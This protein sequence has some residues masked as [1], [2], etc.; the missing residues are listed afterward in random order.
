MARKSPSEY[1][2]DKV[3]LAMFGDEYHGTRS[4]TWIAEKLGIPKS[5]VYW[6]RKHPDRI[7]ACQYLRLMTMVQQ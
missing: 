4:P 2:A 7:P 5:T 6:W 3:S 1:Y